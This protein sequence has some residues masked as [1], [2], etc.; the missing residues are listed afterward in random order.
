MLTKWG[1][2]RNPHRLP[3]EAAV[4]AVF[5]RV[6]EAE[7]RALYDRMVYESGRAATEIGLWLFDPRQAARVDES[8][9][10]CPVLAI[11]GAEDRVTPAAVVRKV[12]EKYRTVSTYREFAGQA[13]WVLGQP[14]WEEV[15]GAVAGWLQ[16]KG[17]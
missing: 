10:T 16:E 12:A 15:A 7:R 11:A 8:R 6:P 1:F 2:W 5:H 13:H 4:Y 17:V 3:Y 9:V 14:G